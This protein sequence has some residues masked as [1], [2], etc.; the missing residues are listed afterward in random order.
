MWHGLVQVCPLENWTLAPAGLVLT[1]TSC[2]VPSMTVAQ[3]DSSSANKTISLFMTFPLYVRPAGAPCG[4]R[5]VPAASRRGGEVHQ[6]AGLH[7]RP[8]RPAPQKMPTTG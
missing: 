3:P 5:V 7:K 6:R 2:S 4:F 1:A 8:P